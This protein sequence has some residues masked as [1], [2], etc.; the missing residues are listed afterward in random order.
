MATLPRRSRIGQIRQ[1]WHENEWIYLFVGLLLG[2]L[3][4]PFF[5]LVNTQFVELLQN[6]VPEAVGIIFTVVIIDRLDSYRE[7]QLIKEQLMRQMHSY[8]NHMALQAIEEMRVLGH[9]QDGSLIGLNL[10]GANLQ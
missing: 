7:H 2:L 8:Y 3:A 5:D 9:L 6:L 10:R 1:L 4:W